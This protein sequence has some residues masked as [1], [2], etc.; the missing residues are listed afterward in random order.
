MKVDKQ[1]IKELFK[2]ATEEVHKLKVKPSD[3]ELLKLYANYKQAT[4]G[5]INIEKPSFYMFKDVAKWNEWNK[6]KGLTKLQARIN[7][8]KI[9]EILKQNYS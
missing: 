1:Q 2:N 9:V 5:D 3:D 4:I 7:Y 8:I 6:L